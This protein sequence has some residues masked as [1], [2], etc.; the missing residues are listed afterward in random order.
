MFD[1]E[2]AVFSHIDKYQFM[3]E[4]MWKTQCT[5]YAAIKCNIGNKYAELILSFL[6]NK[7]WDFILAVKL[8]FFSIGLTTFSLM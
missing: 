6:Y 3:M 7:L 1:I 2:I 4:C 8:S 5:S